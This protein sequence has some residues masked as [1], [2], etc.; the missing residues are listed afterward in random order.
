ME[1]YDKQIT[2]EVT[3]SPKNKK[4]II[5]ISA[6]AAV[7][8]L[9]ILLSSLIPALVLNAKIESLME[10]N[11]TFEFKYFV[12][13]INSDNK[14]YRASISEEYALPEVLEVPST[15]DNLPI[16]SF[17][18]SNDFI[19][20][21]KLGENIKYFL[22]AN[23]DDLENLYL[24]KT[25]DVIDFYPFLQSTE[26]TPPAVHDCKNLRFIYLSHETLVKENVIQNCPNYDFVFIDN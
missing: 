22:V 19:K 16:T 18:C 26:Y 23:M 14:S 21:L 4:K 9:L 7:V 8:V 24:P 20:T 25:L 6:I 15:F 11:K 10:A 17:Y 2:S 13:S 5:L 12:F 1:N 3:K